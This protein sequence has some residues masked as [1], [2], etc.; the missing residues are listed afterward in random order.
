MYPML[1]VAGPRHSFL[2]EMLRRYQKLL[3][4]SEDSKRKEPIPEDHSMIIKDAPDTMIV[5][6]RKF[7]LTLGSGTVSKL[8]GNTLIKPIIV[9][10]DEAVLSGL[11]CSPQNRWVKFISGEREGDGLQKSFSVR[12]I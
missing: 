12:P 3:E 6:S 8:L 2:D 9:K 10:V 5:F 11:S 1:Y 4:Q 7:S